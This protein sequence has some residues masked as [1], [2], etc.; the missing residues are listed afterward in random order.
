L[1]FNIFYD[2]FKSRIIFCGGFSMSFLTN[3]L[4]ELFSADLAAP[5]DWLNPIIKFLDGLLI[6]LTIIVAVAGAIWVIILGVQLARAESADKAQE[7][8]K[9][10]INVAVAIV[11]AIVFIWLLSWFAANVDA[12][13]GKGDAALDDVK[14]SAF[15]YFL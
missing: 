1:F 9:R 8:K 4:G 6:P 2:I 5:Y 10:L 12:I 11:A 15:M 14:K 13:F 7:A 3:L